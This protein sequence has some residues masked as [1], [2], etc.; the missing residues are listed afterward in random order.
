MKHNPTTR[1]AAHNLIRNGGRH[2]I[3]LINQW[4]Y[5]MVRE[6]NEAILETVQA[7]K[8]VPTKEGWRQV[9]A[10]RKDQICKGK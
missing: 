2:S 1:K 4:K 10:M 6:S 7:K 5:D 9:L 8:A 3:C